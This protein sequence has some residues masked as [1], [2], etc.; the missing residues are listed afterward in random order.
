MVDI[1]LSLLLLSVLWGTSW[2]GY[3]SCCSPHI[4][5]LHELGE[6][7]GLTMQQFLGICGKVWLATCPNFGIADTRTLFPIHTL[8][9]LHGVTSTTMLTITSLAL[10]LVPS[11]QAKI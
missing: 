4:L 9:V 8:E 6:V 10:N 11:H 1:R 2:N 5:V 3:I 7:L